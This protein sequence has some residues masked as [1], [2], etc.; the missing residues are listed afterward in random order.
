MLKKYE[1]PKIL[2]MNLVGNE[3][4]CGSCADQGAKCIS[5][6]S[7]LKS[8]MIFLG[9]EDKNGDGDLSREEYY[10][11][12]LF[13]G[14]DVGCENIIEAYCKFTSTGNELVAWS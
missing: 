4:L 1:K 7:N 10:E 6:D 14:E 8:M 2:M 11:A 13:G 9:A 5:N 12:K 3:Q